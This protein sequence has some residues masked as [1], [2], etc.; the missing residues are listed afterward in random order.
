[1][2]WMV[3][4]SLQGCEANGFGQTY[5]LPYV[6]TYLFSGLQS[7]I[8][9]RQAIC[10]SGQCRQANMCFWIAQTSLIL[11]QNTIDCFYEMLFPSVRT[12]NLLKDFI[13]VQLYISIIMSVIIN[14]FLIYILFNTTQFIYDLNSKHLHIF[15]QGRI[16]I[17]ANPVQS[18]IYIYSRQ[19][20]LILNFG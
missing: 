2:P 17:I 1:M 14:I 9:R 6:L 13:K 4:D 7:C 10:A 3:S 12:G 11:V 20:N 5:C 8:L 16:Q 18:R 15:I 19:E